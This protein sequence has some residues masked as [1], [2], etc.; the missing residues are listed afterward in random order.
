MLRGGSAEDSGGDPKLMPVG[1]S[2]EPLCAL[3]GLLLPNHSVIGRPASPS[4]SDPPS[5]CLPLRL[6]Q[7]IPSVTSSGPAR[8]VP[9][10]LPPEQAPA[11]PEGKE[12]VTVQ[13]RGPVHPPA[14]AFSCPC[15]NLRVATQK[16]RVVQASVALGV[17]PS[18]PH[19]PRPN[20]ALPASGPGAR[21][22][23]PLSLSCHHT[24]LFVHWGTF[25]AA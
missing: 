8:P 4:P 15:V 5:L 9:C 19:P 25:S 22:L 2:P 21:T 12:P 14:P 24:R 17:L 10:P 11:Y 13:N 16:C 3:S 23:G 6:P 20:W 18:L 1:K 7:L